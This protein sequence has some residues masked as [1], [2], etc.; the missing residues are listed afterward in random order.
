M[1]A[2]LLLQNINA[3]NEANPLVLNIY[4]SEYTKA[5]GITKRLKQL[6]AQLPKTTELQHLPRPIGMEKSLKPTITFSEFKDQKLCMKLS[7]S[8][9]ML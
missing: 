7:I 8:H 9:F 2:S 3:D 6:H 5:L 4:Y 1:M